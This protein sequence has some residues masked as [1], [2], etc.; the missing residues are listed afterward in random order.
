MNAAHAAPLSTRGTP[1]A[2]KVVAPP[3]VDLY[4]PVHKGLR[5]AFGRTLTI[6]GTADAGDPESVR[7]GLDAVRK[8][9]FVC[10]SHLEH[11]NHYV[12]AAIAARRPGA[13]AALA[14]DHEEHLAAMASL[15]AEV[16]RCEAGLHGVPDAHA[17]H[18]LYLQVAFF[19][20]ENLA[21]MNEEE[22]LAQPLLHEIYT[23]DEL[24]DLERRLVS[25]LTPEELGAFGP[26]MLAGQSRAG[27]IEMVAGPRSAMPPEVF[28]RWLES[29]V[30][31]LSAA[32][33]DALFAALGVARPKVGS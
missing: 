22:T 15:R 32:D 28:P 14:H 26:L 30:V 17:L 8:L 1:R 2:R 18:Q 5:F 16:T 21:H 10:L 11:E 24:R 13:E 4:G 7:A 33:A 9:L 20:G 25:S 29:M 27:R 3:L 6:L 12:L 23:A 31:Y 19:V